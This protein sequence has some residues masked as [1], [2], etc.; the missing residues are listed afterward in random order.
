MIFKSRSMKTLD[1]A[2]ASMEETRRWSEPKI[3]AGTLTDEER[4]R[5][6]QELKRAAELGERSL[7]ESNLSLFGPEVDMLKRFV[8]E[9][10][11]F[12]TDEECLAKRR[13]IGDRAEALAADVPSAG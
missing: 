3:S 12:M 2:I 10:R 4:E 5:R 7:G 9:G 8:R 11:L 6:H 13:D 1:E